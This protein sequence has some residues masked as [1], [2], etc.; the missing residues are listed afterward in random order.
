[1]FAATK[2]RIGCP[3]CEMN[4]R[5]KHRSRSLATGQAVSSTDIAQHVMRSTQA[6]VRQGRHTTPRAPF[7]CASGPRTTVLVFGPE[8]ESESG[9]RAAS[10][11]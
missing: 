1:M 11:P 2:Q 9:C 3:G 7:S 8:R 10:L 6:R 4:S 5:P